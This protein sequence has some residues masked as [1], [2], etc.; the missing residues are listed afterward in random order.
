MFSWFFVILIL[1]L[2]E[3]W[4]NENFPGWN[5]VGR[6]FGVRKCFDALADTPQ[7]R[8]NSNKEKNFLFSS[9]LESGFLLFWI[10]TRWNKKKIL[11]KDVLSRNEYFMEISPLSICNLECVV[12]SKCWWITWIQQMICNYFLRWYQN[13]L[14]HLCTQ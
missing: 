7:M 12:C 5:F 10:Y 6:I 11:E 8:Q 13:F 3:K 4:E 1:W 14:F 9:S 2:W